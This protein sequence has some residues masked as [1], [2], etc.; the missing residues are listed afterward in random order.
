MRSESNAQGREARPGSGRV[1]SPIG[2]RILK[3]R[4]RES[5]SQGRQARLLSGQVQSPVCLPLHGR[6]TENSNPSARAPVRFPDD[7][8]TLTGSSSKS[9]ER[10]TRTPRLAAR[11]R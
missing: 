9:G 5:N 1:P 3:R 8:G 6:R 7:A 10:T 4:E 2:L 11:S